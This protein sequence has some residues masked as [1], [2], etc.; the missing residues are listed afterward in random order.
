[1]HTKKEETTLADKRKRFGPVGI[2]VCAV[3]VLGTIF[4][5]YKLAGKLKKLVLN[6]NGITVSE[7]GDEQGGTGDNG[8]DDRTDRHT[9]LNMTPVELVMTVNSETGRIESI[10][11]AVLQAV[12]GRLDYIRLSE[13]VSYTMSSQ[14]YSELIVDNTE[15]PQTVTLSEIYHYYHNDRAYDAARRIVSELVNFN[16]LYYTAVEDV[17][18]ADLIY[19][20]EY[21]TE[22]DFVHDRDAIVSAAY[23]TPGSVKGAMDAA[24]EGAVTNWSMA[25]R[26][27]YLDVYDGLMGESVTFTDAPII[28]H[29]E[30]CE[31]DT[32]GT[33]AVLYGILY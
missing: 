4:V 13:R 29:N 15:L 27:R 7:Q 32:A 22:V 5:C 30:T 17:K 26:L 6:S 1:M 16:I 3:L 10:F 20:R 18:L 12:G 8:P 9:A 21:G 28:E 23:G 2:L 31:L 11:I 24:L 33:G 14:L 25:D 19:I